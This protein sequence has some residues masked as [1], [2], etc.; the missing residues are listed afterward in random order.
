MI[1]IAHRGC[2]YPGFNQ[3]TIRSFEKVIEQGV[4][5]IEL[6]VQLDADGDL[7]IVHNLD[8]TQVSTGTGQIMSSSTDYL[9]SLHAG[10][11]Q[12]GK[13][14]IPFLREVLDLF[15][16][17]PVEK[18]PVLHMEL[19]GNDTGL[20]AGEM[21]REYLDD[22]R[23]AKTDILVSSFN[24]AELK[25][26]HTICPELD[27]ALLDGAIR[28]QPLLDRLPD[29][30]PYF[31]DLFAYGEEDYMLPRFP[32]LDENLALLERLC[33]PGAI[34]DGL[35]VE[36]ECCLSGGYYTD[37]LFDEA[38][39]MKAKSV[40]LWF[41]SVTKDVVDRAHGEGLAVLLYTINGETDLLKAADMGVDGIFT[42]FYSQ[43]REVLKDYL[44]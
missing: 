7:P 15:A 27:L 35:K 22:G 17:T 25:Q 30:E 5:A 9:K 12:R 40:N 31:S 24:W 8:L 39:R 28:R 38:Q 37:F 33:P 29:S 20:P 10:D 36:L 13:D 4:P 3:N 23:L 1:L 34:F 43:S 26:I 11:P 14:R 16:A 6:D 19:K 44:D 41:Q 18:R 32:T 42:D 21:T 2:S